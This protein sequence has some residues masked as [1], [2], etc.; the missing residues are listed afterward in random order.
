MAYNNPKVSGHYENLSNGINATLVLAT[1]FM[2]GIA[3]CVIVG[4][5]AAVVW[6]FTLTLRLV[7]FSGEHYIHW[8]NIAAF[9]MVFLFLR[10]LVSKLK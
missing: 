1:L 8:P 2:L 3:T 7:E 6:S 4:A 5:V 9:L 10:L